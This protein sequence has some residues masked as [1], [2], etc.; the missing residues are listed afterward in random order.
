[1]LVDGLHDSPYFRFV[2]IVLAKF[3]II[4]SG[5]L[6]RGLCGDNDGVRSNDFSSFFD[7]V[8]RED[9]ADFGNLWRVGSGEVRP[10][11]GFRVST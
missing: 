3:Y 9:A 11:A 1:M 8:K 6:T 2:A 7:G 5:Q 4:I 10:S